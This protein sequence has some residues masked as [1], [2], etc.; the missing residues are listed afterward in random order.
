MK[1][2][3]LVTMIAVLALVVGCYFPETIE[4]RIVFNPNDLP[5]LVINYHNIS[6][7]DEKREE[8]KKSFDEMIG[9]L[10]GEKYLVDSAEKGLLIRKRYLYVENDQLH[11]EIVGDAKM[12]EELYAIFAGK[13]ER[14]MIYDGDDTY[15]LVETNGKVVKTDRNTVIVWPEEMKEIYWKEKLIMK[16]EEKDD[17]K[18]FYQNVSKMVAMFK[19]YQ[20]TQNKE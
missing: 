6:S 19:D 11:A 2:I 12:L 7:S 10:Y 17:I 8:L 3:F 13:D 5:T 9:D 4:T 15:E 16:D 18:M 20:K 1:R 14:F